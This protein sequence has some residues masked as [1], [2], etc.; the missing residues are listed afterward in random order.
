[1]S[2]YQYFEFRALDRPLT[3][4]QMEELRRYSTRA[5]ISPDRFVNVYHYGN[6]RG[7][8]MKLVEKYFDAFLIFDEL[9]EPLLHAARAR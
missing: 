3:E 7:D 9:G 1:L 2:E 5:E 8:P 6:S 4:K